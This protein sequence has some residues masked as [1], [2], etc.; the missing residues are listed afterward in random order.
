MCIPLIRKAKKG[1]WKIR[2]NKDY[3]VLQ[4]WLGS[5]NRGDGL[6]GVSQ[7]EY[8]GSFR[9]SQRKSLEQSFSEI[10]IDTKL[11][12][13]QI[14]TI[15]G[16]DKLD[17]S[18]VDDEQVLGDKKSFDQ[19]VSDYDEKLGSQID[20]GHRSEKKK[21][22]GDVSG[23]EDDSGIERLFDIDLV[24]CSEQDSLDDEKRS[25]I[26]DPIAVIGNS[27]SLLKATLQI[28]V[29]TMQ[30]TK[31]AP[32]K[33][34][35]PK[36]SSSNQPQL[37]SPCSVKPDKPDKFH[38]SIVILENEP[39]YLEPNFLEWTFIDS[40]SN[41]PTP[42]PPS[43]YQPQTLILNDKNQDFIGQSQTQ[44]TQLNGYG[45]LLQKDTG[46]DL[47][48]GYWQNGLKHGKTFII[49]I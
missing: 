33:D 18:V 28:E 44:Q 43:P 40:P 5:L 36:S 45:T 35:N 16:N 38:P 13:G 24:D 20:D 37:L 42:Q 14:E 3:W 41:F 46:Q 11:T 49:A 4:Y 1:Y 32:L 8:E 17:P 39:F 10:S 27:N 21:K 22:V 26:S 15:K 34:P 31:P 23:L 48:T 47:Y 2:D 25:D 29:E 6:R 12:A 9:G 7:A 19:M 30:E